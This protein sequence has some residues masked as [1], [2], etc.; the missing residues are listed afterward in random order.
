MTTWD[1][2]DKPLATEFKKFSKVVGQL[3]LTGVSPAPAEVAIL[4]PGEWART[5]RR[6]F[7]LRPDRSRSYAIR[8]NL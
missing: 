7:A 3:D 5:A 4:I 8:F 1:R 2:Q 6:L